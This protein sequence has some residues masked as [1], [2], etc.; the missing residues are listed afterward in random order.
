MRKK[1]SISTV[2]AIVTILTTL[3]VSNQAFAQPQ[4]D[5]PC[6]SEQSALSGIP[7]IESLRI[8]YCNSAP[9][10]EGQQTQLGNSHILATQPGQ[11]RVPHLGQVLERIT[12]TIHNI[13]KGELELSE[14][15]LGDVCLSCWGG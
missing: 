7:G 15:P 1:I 14:N 13:L 12:T 3:T 10:L 2:L 4:A 11:D 8:L 5:I 9:M 6:I